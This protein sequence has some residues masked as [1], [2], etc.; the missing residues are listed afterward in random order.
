M[1][2]RSS[3]SSSSPTPH[4]LTEEIIQKLRLLLQANPSITVLPL[5]YQE[6]TTNISISH[7]IPCRPRSD[8]TNIQTLDPI[9][10]RPISD[11]INIQTLANQIRS[12]RASVEEKLSNQA[13]IETLNVD[14]CDFDC[15]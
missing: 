5:T 15:Y 13:S 6:N 14:W 4:P 7:P 3:S 12:D 1:E 2:S 9:P 8:Q 11:Q 10:C